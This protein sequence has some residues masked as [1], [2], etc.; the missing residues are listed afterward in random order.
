MKDKELEHFFRTYKLVLIS[1]TGVICENVK[2]QYNI[3]ARNPKLLTN[4]NFF[5]LGENVLAICGVGGIQTYHYVIDYLSSFLPLMK[6]DFS[7]YKVLVEK[8]NPY[9]VQ[10]LKIIRPDIL[11]CNIIETKYTIAENLISITNGHPGAQIRDRVNFLRSRV[12]KSI[13]PKRKRDLLVLSKR[14]Y[15]RL[16]SNWEDLRGLCKS[17]CEKFNL[18]LYIHDDKSMPSIKE[19]LL[20]FASAKIVLGSHG[21]GFVNILACEQDTLFIE[22]KY[23]DR[24]H[25]GSIQEEPRCFEELASVIGLNYKKSLV[26]D[27][28]ASINEIGSLIEDNYKN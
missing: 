14:N 28:K 17:F 6:K 21:A 19:Q 26:R 22:C 8:K 2:D 23:Q 3:T 25:G 27:Q 12:M 9:T 15:S 7:Q 11:E 13:K 20:S 1:N 16:I 5:S 4:T 18:K 24:N 10:W